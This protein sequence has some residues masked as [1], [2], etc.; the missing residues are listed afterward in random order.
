MRTWLGAWTVLVVLA[1]TALAASVSGEMTAL[2]LSLPTHGTLDGRPLA[3]LVSGD[4]VATTLA[5]RAARLHVVEYE[6]TRLALATGT[7]QAGPPRVTHH[8]FT[9][10]ELSLSGA[11]PGSMAG[12]YPRDGAT[13]EMEATTSSLHAEA[14]STLTD[15]DEASADLDAWWYAQEVDDPHVAVAARGVALMTGAWAVKVRGGAATIESDEGTVTLRTGADA[16]APGHATIRWLLIES[17]AIDMTL[18][19]GST[20]LLAALVEGHASWTGAARVDGASGRLHADGIEYEARM[21]SATV[22][23]DLRARLSPAP[24]SG[25]VRLLLGISGDM[26]S[27]SLAAATVAPVP[28]GSSWTGVWILAAAVVLLGGG[29]GVAFSV[30]RRHAPM[31]PVRD[32]VV[33]LV[34]IVQQPSA[35]ASAAAALVK[36]AYE[37]GDARN[38]EEAAVLFARA[39]KLD[40]THPRVALDEGFA[41]YMAQDHAGAIHVLEEAA[42]DS[43]DG[44][45]ELLCAYCALAAGDREGAGSFILQA[46]EAPALSDEILSQIVDDPAA[47]AIWEPS[48]KLRAVLDRVKGEYGAATR[49]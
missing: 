23:G 42:K 39:R 2:S 37:Q 27:T 45:A 8:N 41:R 26:R 48:R 15:Q 6:E 10:A 25:P 21:S 4:L 28:S 22:D 47:R 34:T 35:K 49:F 33:P 40:P 24:T 31:S 20:L 19:T 14:R 44:E 1:P 11:G 32:P 16:S 30:R 29:A 18:D 9:N 7:L 38:W 13:F 46:L 36:Q 17:Q 5:G 3:G 43:R 12:F